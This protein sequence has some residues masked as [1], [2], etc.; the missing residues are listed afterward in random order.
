MAGLPGIGRMAAKGGE[1]REEDSEN[2]R[3]L[4]AARRPNKFSPEAIEY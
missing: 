1:Y 4:I 2:R 3:I